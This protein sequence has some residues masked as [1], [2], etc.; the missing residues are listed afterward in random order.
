MLDDPEQLPERCSVTLDANES[1][2]LQAEATCKVGRFREFGS[3]RAY[4][5]DRRILW[6]RR[7][8]PLIGR[9][10]PW[11]PDLVEIR[12]EMIDRVNIERDLTRAWLRIEVGGR[13]YLLRL[14]VGPYPALRDNPETT[15]RWHK[16]L[17][18]SC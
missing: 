12:R 8:T 6:I 18:G 10:L 11:I 3:G 16:V 7:R 5:T 9:L 17:Q 2:V 15:E 14:G 4:V 1:I 13:I